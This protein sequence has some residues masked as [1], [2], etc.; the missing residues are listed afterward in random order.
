MLMLHGVHTHAHKLAFLNQYAS[1]YN[2]N[3]HFDLI[4]A[5]I[6]LNTKPLILFK[7]YHNQIAR[8][9]PELLFHIKAKEPK[10]KLASQT[11]S[12]VILFRL[13]KQDIIEKLNSIEAQRS[14]YYNHIKLQKII[15]RANAEDPKHINTLLKC[16]AFELVR[17]HFE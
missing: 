6:N 11:N 16:Y 15:S 17:S 5:R 3:L 7:E 4:K 2:P 9:Y 1:F 8:N 12:S 14:P 10:I 13:F